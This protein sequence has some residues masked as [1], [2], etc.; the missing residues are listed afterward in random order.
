VSVT[1]DPETRYTRAA[2]G[3]NIAYQVSGDGRV[4]LA[5]FHSP[6]P[7]DLMS[8]D[9]YFVR[10]RKRLDAFSRTVWYDPRGFGAF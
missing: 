10:L 5:V 8:E 9:P 7:I 3:T 4:E 6:Y 1:N 2:D